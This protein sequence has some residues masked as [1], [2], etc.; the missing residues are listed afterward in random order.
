MHNARWYNIITLLIRDVQLPTY[1]TNIICDYIRNRV[2]V[3]DSDCGVKEW[4]PEDV[5][6]VDD[7]IALVVVDKRV[8]IVQELCYISIQYK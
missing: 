6:M 7:H 4:L 5:K 3:Y 1:L 8:D 2:L